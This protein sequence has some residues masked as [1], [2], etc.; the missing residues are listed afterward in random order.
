MSWTTQELASFLAKKNIPNS[1][2]SFY[3][4]KEDAICL[5]KINDL[6]V[7]YYIER[8]EKNELACG[9]TEAQALNVM[10]LFLLE[11]HGALR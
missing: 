7:V 5:K 8:G 9:K 6:W 10:K 11:A 1:S 4:D 2:F 3:A